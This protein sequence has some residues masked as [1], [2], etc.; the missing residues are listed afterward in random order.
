KVEF[1]SVFRALSRKFKILNIPNV[2]AH[3]TSYEHG[4]VKKHDSLKLCIKSCTES[5]F[6]WFFVHLL[7]NLKYWSFPTYLP[8][9]SRTSIVPRKTR[10]S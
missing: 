2:F 10:W 6:D 3:G 1:Q 7:K 4:F 9:G 8:M 5:R